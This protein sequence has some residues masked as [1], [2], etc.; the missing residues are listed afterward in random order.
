V[1]YSNGKWGFS[2][3]KQILVECGA[4]LDGKYPG[5]EIWREFFRRVGWRKGESYLNY[6]DLTFDLQN[7]FTGEFP[8]V[9]AEW[10]LV[11]AGRSW[12]RLAFSS[13]ASRLVNCSR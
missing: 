3:Q 9:C 6:S 1:K 2:V 10:L 8:G 5:D 4:K 11:V 13:L 12:G 7:S